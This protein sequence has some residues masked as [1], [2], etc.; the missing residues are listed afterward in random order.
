MKHLILFDGPCLLCHKAILAIAKRDKRQLFVFSSLQGE[1][2]KR[3]DLPAV[4]SV[5]LIE[6][7]EKAPKIYVE[8]RAFGRIARLLGRFAYC[9]NWLYRIIARNRS[10]LCHTKR[11]ISKIPQLP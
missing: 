4:D 8:G 10:K 5:I 2:A 3:F 7:F 6:D 1:T 9:P 11:D